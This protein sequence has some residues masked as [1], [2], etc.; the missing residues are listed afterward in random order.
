MNPT[1]HY[2]MRTLPYAYRGEIPAEVQDEIRESMKSRAGQMPKLPRNHSTASEEGRKRMG[3]VK[4]AQATQT[5]LKYRDGMLK[6]RAE[7][8]TMTGIA[9][10][11]GVSWNTVNR[12]L[13][14]ADAEAQ[15]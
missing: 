3:E 4:R 11:F 13:K 5:F 12:V 6:M 7:G 14:R 8:T 9:R 1:E 10:E 15:Q 2:A